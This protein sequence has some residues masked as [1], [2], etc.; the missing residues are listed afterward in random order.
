VSTHGDTAKEGRLIFMVA[1]NGDHSHNNSSRYPTIGRP[2]ASEARTPNATMIRNLNL[3][4]NTVRLQTIMETIQ[5]IA[6]EGSPLMALAQQGAEVVNLI[7]VEKSVGNP[8][9][10]PSVGNND[11]ARHVRS[12][13]ASSASS[14]HR[15]ADNDT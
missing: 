15:L 9:M 8:Q 11:R 1:P 10:E 6:P 4:F 2:E 13:A 7:V 12:E 14:N 3:A 5:R